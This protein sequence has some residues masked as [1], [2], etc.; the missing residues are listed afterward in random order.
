MIEQFVI[1]PPWPKRKGGK[2]KTRP[3]QGRSLAYETMSVFDIF[4][5]LDCEVFPRAATPH[6][7]FFWGIE[8][9]LHIGESE[10]LARGYRLHARIVW[11]K[12]NGVAPAFTIRYSHEYLSW[13]YKPKLLPVARE[14][15]GKFTSVIRERARQHSR[16]P[17][18]AY[19]MIR[20]LYPTSECEDVFSREVRNGWT[21][22]GDQTTL[23]G[24]A[25]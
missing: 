17:D 6:N 3:L 4:A 22:F 12:G 24:D 5:L 8:Q 7:V 2:R 18:A 10:M 16:K 15:R 11:D 13:F 9:F 25:A 14:S 19:A 1:D 23:F 21:Q 20:A